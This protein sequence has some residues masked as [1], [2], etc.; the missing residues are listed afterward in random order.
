M[1]IFEVENKI[2]SN[3]F[4]GSK[5]P[6]ILYHGTNAEFAKFERVAHGIFATP[7]MGYADV[8]ST[9]RVIPFYANVKKIKYLDY[10]NPEDDAII[11]LFYDRDYSEV[12][13]YLQQIAPGGYDCV[14]Y[15]GEGDSVLLFN[16]IQLMNAN[17]GKEM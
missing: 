3:P 16:G 4:P 6:G 1:R 7:H 10:K 13:K 15:G 2:I 12:A 17:T 8:Y 11:E 5:Y 14:S 9:G